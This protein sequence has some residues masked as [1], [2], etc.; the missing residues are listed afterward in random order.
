MKKLVFLSCII[1][2][3]SSADGTSK[4]LKKDILK[5]FKRHDY[6]K[7]YKLL[8][9]N[10]IDR[11][12]L[13]QRELRNCERLSRLSNRL[14]K[15]HDYINTYNFYEKLCKKEGDVDAC[16]FV[17]DFNSYNNGLKYFNHKYSEIAGSYKKVCKKGNAE[18]CFLLGDLYLHKGKYSEAVKFYKQACDKGYKKGCEEYNIF[19]N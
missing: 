18:G 2:A 13:S 7:V 19:N 15:R 5:S 16:S 17:L 3:F 12:N 8:K 11:K 10:C 6:T 4:N 1:I 14:I 9:E